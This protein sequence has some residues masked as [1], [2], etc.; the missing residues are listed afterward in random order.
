MDV[1]EKSV[2]MARKLGE[3]VYFEAISN[4]IHPVHKSEK[5]DLSQMPGW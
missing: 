3:P 1:I 4:L 5:L 2:L